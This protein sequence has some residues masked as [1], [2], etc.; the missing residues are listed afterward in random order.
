L[1]IPRRRPTPSHDFVTEPEFNL[2]FGN[3]SHRASLDLGVVML[4]MIASFL[5]RNDAAQIPE[6]FSYTAPPGGTSTRSHWPIGSIA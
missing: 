3:Q 2:V 1:L 4:G 6:R 5:T